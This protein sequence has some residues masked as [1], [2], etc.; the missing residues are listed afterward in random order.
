VSIVASDE[1]TLLEVFVFDASV[2]V[3]VVVAV[4]VV[5]AVEGCLLEE[6]D[7]EH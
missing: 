7:A 6:D 5:V 3:A 1:E 2:V 4:V